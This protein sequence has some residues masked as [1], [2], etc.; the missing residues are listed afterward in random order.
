[1]AIS[2]GE[3]TLNRPWLLDYL[4][5]LKRLNP[6]KNARLH[7]DTNGSILTSDYID[8]LAEAGMTDIGIDL[9]GLTIETFTRITGLENVALAERYKET[10]WEA[11]KYVHHNH[12]EVFLGIGIP[13]NRD[14]ISVGEIRQMGERILSIDPAIQVCVLDY[15]PEF[16][17][18]E[19]L[20]PGYQE[21]EQV[22]TTLKEI[23]LKTVICQTAYGH[24]GP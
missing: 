9:K 10:A 3:C 13:Y 1:M 18:R 23:G 8:E 19:I 7:V 15:R 22:Y 14:L 17:R 21:M 16:R 2:G 5:E 12:Q 24:I 11:V 20:R 4:K 6:D